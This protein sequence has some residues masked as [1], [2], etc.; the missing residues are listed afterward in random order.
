MHHGPEII[1][2]AYRYRLL[3]SPEQVSAF[4]RISGCGRLVY[5]QAL[6]RERAARGEGLSIGYAEHQKALTAQKKVYPFLAEVPHHTLQAALRDL[7]Q[8]TKRWLSGQNDAP[9]FRR[10]RETP[11]FRFPDPGQFCVESVPREDWRCGA[12]TARGAAS[13]K[14]KYLRAPK[15]GMRAGD[16]GL[17]QV[18]VHRPLKGKVKTCTITREGDHWYASF[19]V[20]IRRRGK[21]EAQTNIATE[22]IVATDP[23]LGEQPGSPGRKATKAHRAG[24][25]RAAAERKAKRNRTRAEQREAVAR[26]AE[27]LGPLLPEQIEALASL[28]V[29][30]A[31][32]GVTNPLVLDTGEMLAHAVASPA[33]ARF[34][35]RL[36]RV[37]ARKQEALRARHGRPAGASLKGL[38]I[39]AALRKARARLRRFRA[40][41]VRR[42]RDMIHKITSALVARFDVIVLEDLVTV[43]MTA[44]ARG[45]AEAPGRRV[46]QKAGLNRAILDRAWGE[47]ARQLAYKLRWASRRRGMKKILLR[48][49]PAHTS[50]TCFSCKRVDGGSRQSQARFLCTGCGHEDHADVNA[51]RNIRESGLEEIA[52][53]CGMALHDLPDALLEH[54]GPEACEA[55]VTARRPVDR[56][57]LPSGGIGRQAPETPLAG[58]SRNSTPSGRLR[59]MQSDPAG[60]AGRDG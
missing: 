21:P 2:K 9:Q 46:A 55:S 58:R 27:A 6:E 56:R 28:R 1:R 17:L 13:A 29:A 30:G 19:S 10:H 14:V 36:Q 35:A 40:K 52:R 26:R 38:E 15:F 47:F 7:E 50:Q 31:D 41:L 60:S 53:A 4:M 39:P 22:R 49:D 54:P 12:I 20:E 44:S 5:N 16:F 8:A 11:H 43:A 57:L 37:K 33:D 23:T 34:E 42:R 32:R 24:H 45:T 59:A 51:A 18:I 3:P 48:V 25:R